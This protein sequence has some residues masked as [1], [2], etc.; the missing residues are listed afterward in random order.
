MFKPKGTLKN[1]GGCG[2]GN[3]EEIGRLIGHI[4]L[5]VGLLGGNHLQSERTSNIDLWNSPFKVTSVW[6]VYSVEQFIPKYIVQNYSAVSLLVE[7]II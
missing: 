5:T 7:F 4:G 6:L 3:W 2:K 1:S